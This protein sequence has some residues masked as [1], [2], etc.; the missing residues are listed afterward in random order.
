MCLGRAFREP[1]PLNS[2]VAIGVGR[3]GHQLKVLTDEGRG[4]CIK[5]WKREPYAGKGTDEWLDS[6]YTKDT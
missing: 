4:L 2:G 5:D 1:A 6:H 3:D